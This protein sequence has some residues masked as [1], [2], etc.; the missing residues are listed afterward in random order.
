MITDTD[1]TYMLPMLPGLNNA[2]IFQGPDQNLGCCPSQSTEPNDIEDCVHTLIRLEYWTEINSVVL[3][4]S[5]PPTRRIPLSVITLVW[6][7]LLVE[8][9]KSMF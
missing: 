8:W 5:K 4:E 1:A 3:R 2:D 6:N 9:Q 7:F